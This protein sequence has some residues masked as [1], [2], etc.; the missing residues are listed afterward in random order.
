[1]SCLGWNFR[2]LRNLQTEDE[3]A[4][5][6]SNKNPKMVFLMET[7]LEKNN[8]ERIGRK[9]KFANI[10]VIPHVNTSGGLALI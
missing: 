2:G 1:M 6:V 10:F 4:T 3:I 9:T 5:L 7:K 8:M